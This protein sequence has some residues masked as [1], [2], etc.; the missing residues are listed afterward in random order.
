MLLRMAV[1]RPNCTMM[2][3]LCMRPVSSN[4]SNSVNIGPVFV[5]V[6]TYDY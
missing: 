1:H 4:E 6:G 2:L 3:L 5:K